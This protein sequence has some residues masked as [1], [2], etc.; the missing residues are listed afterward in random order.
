MKVAF[1]RRTS[2]ILNS[3]PQPGLPKGVIFIASQTCFNTL[4]MMAPALVELKKRG[5]AVVNLVAGMT[6][7]QPVGL[8]Y[9]DRFAGAIPLDLVTRGWQCSWRVDWDSK[10]VE[11]LG[12][13]FYQGFYERLSTASR[14]YFVNLSDA[15]QRS[16]FMSQLQR[17]DTCLRICEDIRASV[18]SRGL[19]CSFVTGNSHVTPYSIFRD[20]ARHHDHPRMNFI[21]CNVA[22]ESYFTNLGSKFANTMCVTDMTLHPLIRAPFLARKDQFEDWYARNSHNNELAVKAES[23]INVNR[24]GSV[25]S[26]SDATLLQE[27]ESAK[28]AGKRIICAFGK[29]PVDLNVPFDGGPA[30]SDMAD[31]LNHT[32]EVCGRTDDIFLLVKPHPHELRPEIAL[33]LVE[34]LH[35]LVTGQLPRNVRLLGHRD[36]NVHALAPYLDLALLYNGSSALELTAMG[37]PVMMSSHF[38]R[39]D[40]P[41]DLLYPESREQYAAFL[42][43][44]N[45]RHPSDEL[46]KKAA[47]LICYLGSE[48]I[49]INNRYSVRQITNDK[50]G[51][52]RWR[53]VE[54]RAFLEK[55]DPLMGL[56]AER[57][58][59]KFESGSR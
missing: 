55:G 34:G 9:I 42:S 4:A 50:I 12:I 2:E 53:E 49:S 35:D 48:E 29:V 37:V 36:I 23:L 14:R 39:H 13:N 47:F 24:V 15:Q 21:N 41:I 7:H 16:N 46:R 59:Q 33:D 40:Y 26:Q 44:G 38:G 22:Y 56:I 27:L 30:H 18:L 52:P 5:Y 51:I 11:A 17:S 6:E 57:I 28:R 10:R 32:I 54:V 45:F 19:A 8:D 1:C 25:D 58:V 43:G 20:F 3:V 31:W